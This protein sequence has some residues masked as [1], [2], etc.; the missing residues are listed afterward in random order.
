[1]S[2]LS[3]DGAWRLLCEGNELCSSKCS[4]WRSFGDLGSSCSRTRKFVLLLP[5]APVTSY[6]VTTLRSALFVMC[7]AVHVPLEQ[8]GLMAMCWFELVCRL[9]SEPHCVLP[10]VGHTHRF[11]SVPL[12]LVLLLVLFVCLSV[13]QYSVTEVKVGVY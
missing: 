2:V 4:L 11:S 9:E 5:H 10:A 6:I 7:F 13:L 12:L 3:Q 8:M 1:L